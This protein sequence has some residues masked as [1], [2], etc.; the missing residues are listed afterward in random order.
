MNKEQLLTYKLVKMKNWQY[1]KI[2][3]FIR[4]G[5]E[6]LGIYFYMLK[7]LFDEYGYQETINMMLE[8]DKL[9]NPIEVDHE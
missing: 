4:T 8:I 5:E 7:P 1:D 3:K 9:E 2:L 6:D